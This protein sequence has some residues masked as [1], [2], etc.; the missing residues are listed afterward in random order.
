LWADTMGVADRCTYMPGD[1]FH[2]VP[3]ADAYL[4]KRILHDW[5]DA[6][7][8]QIL[9]TL[10]RAAPPQGRVLIIEAVV[11][12]PDTPH[13]AK[14]FDIHMLIWGTG[15]ERTEEEYAA[16]LAGAGWTYRQTWYPASKM[17]GVVE[18]VKA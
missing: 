11:P 7:C 10:H 4:M 9:A 8:R 17:L 6:Q 1:M 13:F 14:L 2:E 18:G 15:R 12:G 3:R 5:N 16:L